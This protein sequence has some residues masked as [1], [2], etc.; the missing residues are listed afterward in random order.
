MCSATTTAVAYAKARGMSP[1]LRAAQAH[2]CDT[3]NLTRLSEQA[4]RVSAQRKLRVTKRRLESAESWPNLA[5]LPEGSH[6]SHT[7]GLWPWLRADRP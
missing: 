3:K 7:T 4:S 2:D 6:P 1:K 5:F